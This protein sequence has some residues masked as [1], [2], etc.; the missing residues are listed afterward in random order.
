MTNNMFYYGNQY[1]SLHYTDNEST[2][3][4]R[5]NTNLLMTKK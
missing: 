3:V 1:K 5:Q 4:S 2:A